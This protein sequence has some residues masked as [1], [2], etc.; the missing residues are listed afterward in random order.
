MFA[1]KVINKILTE[2]SLKNYVSYNLDPSYF[3]EFS[4]EMKF[5]VEHNNQYGEV[6]SG[7]AFTYKFNTFK[8]EDTDDNWEYLMDNLQTDFEFYLLKKTS[9]KINTS[10]D[11]L[12]AIKLIKDY[13]IEIEKKKI[14]KT[15][16]LDIIANAEEREVEYNRRKALEGLTGIST[17]FAELDEVLNGW[18]RGEELVTILG[19]TNQGKS[20][21]GEKFLTVAWE[22]GDIPLLYSG[23]MSDFIVGARF[24][25]LHANMSNYGITNGHDDL[26]V[27]G[28]SV[29]SNDYGVYIKTLTNTGR[30]FYVITPKELNGKK[31]DNNMLEGLLNS[32]DPKPTIVGIDQYSLMSD[33]VSNDRAVKAE[34]LENITLGLFNISIR[35]GLPVLGNSQAGRGATA[36]DDEDTP[37]IEHAYGSDA[38]GQN[39]TRIISMR[40]TEEGLKM[41]VKK[42]R[43]G[44]NNKTFVY[45]W[46]INEGTFI[47]VDVKDFKKSKEKVKNKQKEK[48]TSKVAAGTSVF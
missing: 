47:A 37:E 21:I 14:K 45:T 4:D 17:G 46:G 23:E 28:E 3:M 9:D 33:C 22:E 32:L 30:P 12:E 18:Q 42:N 8:I 20:W 15:K 10:E 25:T 5:I 29:S 19:R 13:S 40:Q 43:M 39:S 16:V 34:R 36:G 2:K 48:D 31:L 35:H 7:Q 41:S 38:I 11:S 24:D 26:G 6:P 27:N 44:K 1:E